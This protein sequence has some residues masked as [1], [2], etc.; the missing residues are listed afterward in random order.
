MVSYSTAELGEVDDTYGGGCR[1]CLRSTR[2]SL[3]RLRRLLGDDYRVVDVVKRLKCQ[4]CQS[5]QVTVTFLVPHQAVGSLGHL[6]Q[7]SAV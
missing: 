6:F 1:S 4:T 3:E 2:I 5:K 7:E